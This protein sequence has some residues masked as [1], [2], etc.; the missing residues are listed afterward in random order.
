VCT[1]QP[2]IGK[3]L[4]ILEDGY[5]TRDIRTVFTETKC[6]VGKEGSDQLADEVLIDETWFKVIKAQPW[7][8]GIISHYAL[9]VVE[10]DEV[11]NE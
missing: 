9:T 5:N 8:T 7:Q 10:L 2:Y 4:S 3:D 11:L 6:S 1:V